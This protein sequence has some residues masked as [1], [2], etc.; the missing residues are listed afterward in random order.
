[1]PE[2]PLPDAATPPAPPRA[3]ARRVHWPVWAVVATVAG[4]LVLGTAGGALAGLAQHTGRTAASGTAAGNGST[5]DAVSVAHRILPS[6]VTVSTR[7][8]QGASGVGSG[9]V[10]RA[11]GYI[12]TNNHV[13]SSALGGGSIDVT[14]SDGE[15]MSAALVGRDPRSDLAVLKVE[16]SRHLPVIA[17]ADS[18]RVAVGQPVVALGA[19][20]GLSSTVT[21]GIVSA[22]DRNVTVP[23]DGNATTVLVGAIQTDAAI[24]PGNSGGALVDCSGRL[25]GVNTAI[26]TVPNEAGQAGG[27]S[28]GI[29]FAVPANLTKHV[30]GQIIAGE[31]IGYAYLGLQA[32]PLVASSGQSVGLFVQTVTAGGPADAAGLHPGDVITHID[33]ERV[34]S[35]APLNALVVQAKPGDSVR[36]GYVRDGAT[37]ETNLVLGVQ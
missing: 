19:P 27:G 2:A 4:A 21:A 17:L 13:I 12:V 15:T 31:P 5:C 26:A 28:V 18:D 11:D 1:M 10:I 34:T 8:A 23:S 14:F 32:A 29:G 25:I 6:I 20:L 37:A 16:A 22:L 33:G 3:A 7:S 36:I 9:E 24:N 35:L 30:T